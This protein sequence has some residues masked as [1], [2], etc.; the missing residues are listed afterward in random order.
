M[1]KNKNKINLKS[2]QQITLI[3]GKSEYDIAKKNWGFYVT[4]SIQKRLKKFNLEVYLISKSNNYF[5]CLVKQKKKR[6]FKSFLLKKKMKFIQNL[7][8]TQKF[9]KILKVK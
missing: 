9:K 1:E 7:S 5:L 2:D 8:T 3:N 6:L 4:P